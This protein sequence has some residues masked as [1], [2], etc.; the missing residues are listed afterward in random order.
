MLG[1]SQ[2]MFDDLAPDLFSAPL[3]F[4][5][6]QVLDSAGSSECTAASTQDSFMKQTLQL[7]G[8]QWQTI[9]A[10][11]VRLRNTKLLFFMHQWV[12]FRMRQRRKLQLHHAGPRGF[13]LHMV[14]V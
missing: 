11:E 8:R 13:K 2:P 7:R 3:G 1:L 5:P 4:V 6:A 9:Q 10:P 12:P 14:M